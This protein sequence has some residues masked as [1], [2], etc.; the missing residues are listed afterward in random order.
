MK[1]HFDALVRKL[2]LYLCRRQNLP[3]GIDLAVDLG[4]YAPAP[5]RTVLDV[6]ANIGQSAQYFSAQ[7]PKAR[8]YSFE[9]IA[10]TFATLEKNTR[11]LERVSRFKHAMGAHK[12][13]ARIYLDAHECSGL[14][15]LVEARNV[16]N[17]RGSEVIAIET[18]DR[19]CRAQGV[20]HIDL[21]KSDTEG[22][23]LEVLRGAEDYL[24]RGKVTFVLVEAG[25][26]KR[27][28]PV[29][30]LGDLHDYLDTKGY[31]LLD[32]YETHELVY[33]PHP[34]YPRLAFC[35]ALFVN[36]RILLDV[37]GVRPESWSCSPYA[38]E[39]AG[40]ES[41]RAQLLK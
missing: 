41:A 10:E 22:Y 30:F 7:F 40:S 24:E 32:L 19:F 28:S 25:F 11:H 14:N 16:D 8:I 35:T 34:R 4:R 31:Q 26:Y 1:H 17:Q 27:H 21:L 3:R 20:E 15:S 6:G 13:S 9:P 12:G 18:I 39:H 2:G 29:T 23:D 33:V 38:P 5:I 37:L 36:T